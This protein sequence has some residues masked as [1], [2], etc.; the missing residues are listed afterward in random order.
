[1]L[2]VAGFVL[3]KLFDKNVMAIFVQSKIAQTFSLG[4]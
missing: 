3:V 1:M 2:D 4:L